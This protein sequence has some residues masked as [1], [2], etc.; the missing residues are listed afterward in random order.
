MIGRKN[1]EVRLNDRD[2]QVGDLVEHI[3][4]DN[5]PLPKSMFWEITHIHSGLGLIENYVILSL[6]P[7]D[8]RRGE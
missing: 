7:D 8:R 5:Q 3:D 6:Q 4:Y 1:N 2:Y